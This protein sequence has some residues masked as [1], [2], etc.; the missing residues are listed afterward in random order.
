MTYD[1]EFE[2]LESI[3]EKVFGFTGEIW[4]KIED[5]ILDANDDKLK[6]LM[7]YAE[8]NKDNEAFEFSCEAIR[9]Q[10]IILIL[11]D[12]KQN[13]FKYFTSGVTSID[14]LKDKY[15]QTIFAIRRIEMGLSED[16]IEE[17]ICFL[18]EYNISPAALLRII[19]DE[20]IIEKEKVIALLI[21]IYKELGKEEFD[22]YYKRNLTGGL[23][24]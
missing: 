3:K 4:G 20:L 2:Y 12:E 22:I 10:R 7:N 13:G 8:I 15:L 16:M 1:E 24:E 23:N 14:E 21:Q 18:V 19:A 5:Y 11:F 6:E 17:A 9:A